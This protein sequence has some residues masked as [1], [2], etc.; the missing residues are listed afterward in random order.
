[1]LAECMS[2]GSPIRDLLIPCVIDF[3]TID[4]VD[5]M[6]DYLI[7]NGLNVRDQLNAECLEE[8]LVNGLYSRRLFIPK[9]TFLTGRI[10]RKPYIDI[11]ISGRV[12]VKNFFADGR[13]DT[14]EVVSHFRYFEGL[15]GRKR[16]LYAHEDTVWVTVDPVKTNDITKAE[17]E[18]SVPYLEQYNILEAKT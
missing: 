7:D 1:M 12:T 4:D 16:V 10:H 18:M 15:P 13:V 14:A 8:K 11:F 3:A 2:P 5:H 6:E 9:G 17:E